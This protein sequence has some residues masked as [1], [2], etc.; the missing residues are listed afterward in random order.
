MTGN[1]AS[2]TKDSSMNEGG[3]LKNVLHRLLL[4]NWV[5]EDE[6]KKW[7]GVENH[8]MPF[9]GTSETKTGFTKWNEVK[10]PNLW[11]ILDGKTEREDFPFFFNEPDIL[12]SSGVNLF[13]FF[14][15]GLRGEKILRPT[16]QHSMDGNTR[17]WRANVRRSIW[18]KIPRPEKGEGASSELFKK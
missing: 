7:W 6:T 10:E 15:W 5:I 12:N 11:G 2:S 14:P 9:W 16:A 3:W 8:V 17:W 4:Q 1:V 13:F 18:S